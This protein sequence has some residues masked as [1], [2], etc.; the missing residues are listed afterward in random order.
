MNPH[1]ETLLRAHPAG[2]PMTDEIVGLLAEDACPGTDPMS[3][4]LRAVFVTTLR[5]TERLHEIGA[6]P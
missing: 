5:M 2:V 4:A 6:K 3:A 1:L